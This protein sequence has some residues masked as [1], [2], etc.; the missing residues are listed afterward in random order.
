[1]IKTRDRVVTILNEVIESDY[2]EL[3][4]LEISDDEKL[5]AITSESMVALIFVTTLEDEF[6]I[7]FNDDEIDIAF[8]NSIDYLAE[9]V[10][11]HLNQ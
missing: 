1:M 4:K 11:G 10:D 5:R 8:F 9:T 6:S 2:A 3:N 7:E